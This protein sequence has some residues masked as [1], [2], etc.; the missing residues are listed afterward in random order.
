M[1]RNCGHRAPV[2]TVA[3]VSKNNRLLQDSTK[4]HDLN[5][6][7]KFDWC[8]LGAKCACVSVHEAYLLDEATLPFTSFDCLLLYV[9]LYNKNMYLKCH[10]DLAMP[11][12]ACLR[13]RHMLNFL[14]AMAL[15]TDITHDAIDD[16]VFS[17]KA[18]YG[19]HVDPS[20]AIWAALC[21]GTRSM[22][23]SPWT[24]QAHASF[25]KGTKTVCMAMRPRT[26]RHAAR[27][28]L[29]EDDAA[30]HLLLLL[31]LPPCTMPHMR[32]SLR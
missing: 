19:G 2:G 29:T 10:A 1:P 21:Y 16:R 6:P 20:G 18:P 14:D 7:S 24:L 27:A 17:C 12:H 5:Y 23:A 9:Q 25:S 26:L 8:I 28:A 11:C 4:M 30:L 13:N 22:T 31:Q 15:C 3:H 32:R